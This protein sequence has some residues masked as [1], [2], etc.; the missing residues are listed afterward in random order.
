[1]P[2]NFS[3]TE[4]GGI[5]NLA[6]LATIKEGFVDG[7]DT[8]SYVKRLELVLKTLNA[9]ALASRE[10]QAESP[11]AH[12]VG[13]M[14]IVHF[15][16]F[17]IVPPDPP[18][19]PPRPGSVPA[20]G[21]SRLLLN[22]TFDGGWEPYMRVIWR[23][24]GTTLDLM[25]CNCDAYPLSH[26]CTFEDYTA[27]VRAHEVQGGFFY[28]DA[29]RSIADHRFLAGAYADQVRSRTVSPA[30]AV[31]PVD[32]TAVALAA[33]RPI[34][35]LFAL[36]PIFPVNQALEAGIL[37]RVTHDILR[38]VRNASLTQ[39][40][41]QTGPV[42][43]RFAL[44]LRWFEQP[45]EGQ[46]AKTGGLPAIVESEVQGGILKSYVGT[47]WGCLVLLRVI[48]AAQAAQAL[49][50]FDVTTAA[51]RH[52]GS[53]TWRNVALTFAGLRALKA[54]AH[55]LARL[56]QEFIDGM[57]AR[58]GVLGD[59]RCNHPDRWA[60]PE[61]YGPGTT[62]SARPMTIDLAI[63]HVVVQLR[64]AQAP[65]DPGKAWQE[66]VDELTT[67]GGFEVLSVQ[68]MLRYPT[69]D[70]S[71]R[72]HFG[73]EDGFSQPQIAAKDPAKAWDD[74][75]PAG[76]I[77]LGY[78][79]QRGDGRVPTDADP[80]FDN[81]S[82]LV[83]RKLR[84]NVGLLRS[85]TARAA[86][87]LLPAAA[88]VAEA[89]ALEATLL[90]QMM[91]RT[92][93][94]VPLVGADPG[95]PTK[96]NFNYTTDPGG[97]VCPFQ[98]HVRR[99]NPR[100]DPPLP[101]IVRRGMSY[102][103]RFDSQPDEPRGLVFMAYNA[104]IAEQFEKIQRWITAST[105]SGGFSGHSDPFLGVPDPG[106]AR[107]F[108][109]SHGGKTVYVDLG[110]EPLAVL[111]WGLYLFVPSVS[112][113]KSLA[114]A[115]ASGTKDPPAPDRPTEEFVRWQ[116][117]LEDGATREA[118][119]KRVRE[120]HG[121]VLRTD[122]GV[123]VGAPDLV[124][125]VFSDQDN[126]SV[127]GYA[128]R[129]ATS[130]GVGYL[131]LDR[132]SGHDQQA[133]GS[134]ATL[135]SV[136]EHDAF[137]AARVAATKYLGDAL[138]FAQAATGARQAS[139]DIGALGES[140]LATLCTTWFGFPDGAHMIPSPSIE[141][142][143]PAQCP[144]HFFAVSRHV[145]GPRP[146][147]LV[148]QVGEGSGKLLRAAVADGLQAGVK[149]PPVAAAIQGAIVAAGGD[150]D[151][152]ARTVAGAMLGFAPT[153]FGNLRN[154]ATAWL[155]TGA[156]SGLQDD[157]LRWQAAHATDDPFQS[158]TGVLRDR[159]VATMLRVPVPDMLWRV[160]RRDHT[161]GAVDIREGEHLVIGILSA[162]QQVADPKSPAHCVIFGGDWRGADGPPPLLA[163]PGYGMAMGTLLG[164]FT[165]LLEAG[166]LR[167]V[168][169]LSVRLG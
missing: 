45:V 66:A 135:A 85:V 8:C 140:V 34:G 130:I 46:V 11:S 87:E 95:D 169:G 125:K 12:E 83:V 56:P 152:V 166:N 67:A 126:Y 102:G 109:F 150:A 24:L 88:P 62:R 132:D 38:T 134:N 35:A 155:Q 44:M 167:P 144:A 149:L 156:L 157:L 26:A 129:M 163:C 42:R 92:P 31:A 80:L 74:A 161:L 68:N 22:V 47:R 148:Q 143:P 40:Y 90:D 158:A 115:L 64:C 36:A 97:A 79:N 84:Q 30:V 89:Q 139:I 33:L 107:P 50:T 57:A 82:F 146:T 165:A 114:Q 16:R 94:G 18:M 112:A 52:D 9:L 145:F 49:A 20:A 13:R 14:R 91:G 15:F 164:V 5:T 7:L 106:H 27:W 137:V 75:V 32:P 43:D 151:L 77:L 113:L 160:A 110:A 131:G 122:Y 41:I 162:S 25:L 142:A 108:G 147:P 124:M 19:A 63:V 78:A 71:S 28:A 48:D 37:L 103:P 70:G 10:A 55:Q 154:V 51:D 101:R 53:A 54:S 69:P 58:A 2:V 65:A 168:G 116:R 127:R 118:A 29:S 1:M 120:A 123:L 99:S 136:T 105:P 96:N 23:D 119:W 159:L 6:L 128:Q 121:G 141:T 39:Q 81:G 73:F 133:P 72:E 138:A 104:S 3:S 153:V 93:E 86:A 111:E 21:R 98:S 76:E 60:L 59:V 117:L 4:L 100:T 61:R 17:A